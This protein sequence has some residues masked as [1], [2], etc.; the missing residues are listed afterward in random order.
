MSSRLPRL[1]LLAFAI[2]LFPL[3]ACTFVSRGEVMV[4]EDRTGRAATATEDDVA[5]VVAPVLERYG[6]K[7]VWSWKES[8]EPCISARG[9]IWAPEGKGWLQPWV[10]VLRSSSDRVKVQI[11][12]RGVSRDSKVKAMTEDVAKALRTYFGG[13]SVVV[14]IAY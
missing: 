2:S 12:T 5:R 4:A 10:A 11:E 1:G 9:C 7:P 14:E 13:G 6:L 8:S 3:T